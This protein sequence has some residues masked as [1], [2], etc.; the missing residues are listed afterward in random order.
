MASNQS[1]WSHKLL[2]GRLGEMIPHPV[3]AVQSVLQDE[4]S[5]D[6][7]VAEKRGK[8]PWMRYDEMKVLLRGRNKGWADI[9]VSFNASRPV[10]TMDVYGTQKILKIDMINQVLVELGERSLSKMDSGRD[11]LDQ[12]RVL[13]LST[14]KNAIE[15]LG[16]KRM[17]SSL[18]NLYT[19]FMESVA[20]GGD[21]PVT[22]KMAFETVRVAEEICNRI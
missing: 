3:Y 22:P 9:Y 16:A 2:G 12:S 8:Y 17:E 6:T 4:L 18:R 15:Y 10:I 21:P 11:L 19:S 20:S 14:V 5:V 1:H 13:F 7:I